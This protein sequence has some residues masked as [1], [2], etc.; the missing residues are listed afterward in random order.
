MRF[1]LILIL[2]L[3]ALGTGWALTRPQ[4]VS[5]DI[6]DGLTA[7]AEHGA[8]V[9]AAAGCGSCHAAADGPDDLMT[10]GKE[11]QS[12]FGTFVAPNISTDPDHGIG[13]WS[14]LE[15]ASAIMSGVGRDGAHLYPAF[16]YTAY[17][18]AAPQDIYDLI[19]YLRTLPADDAPSAPHHLG[20]PFNQRIAL[21][22]WKALNADDAWVLETSD[23]QLE[24]GR[25]LVEALGHCAECHSPRD[26]LGGLQ[27]ENWMA[28]APNPSGE[29]RIPN[30]T[31]AELLW[32][33]DDII[34]YLQSGFTPAFDVA[35]GSMAAV[36]R[37]TSQLTDD[38]R[39]AIAAYLKAIP[40][41][42][43]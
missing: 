32:S 40:P 16:P 3:V 7:D 41:V 13:G 36:I 14:D 1:R 11:F 39:A 2:G 6:F 42:A 8:Y 23:P 25:Y 5:P 21:G 17:A 37:N 4:P 10:G 33:E 30:I 43:N 29:G 18:K 12:D 22:P 27:R 34:A 20:F 35:G 38:D 28:G 15:L 31:P 26:A 9:F 19:A 24:R